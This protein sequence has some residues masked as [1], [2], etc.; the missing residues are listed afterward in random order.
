MKI[1]ICNAGSTSLKYRLLDMADESTLASGKMERVGSQQGSYSHSDRLGN[2]QSTTLPIPDYKT[3]IHLMLEQLVGTGKVL[4]TLEEIACVGF[5]VVHAKGV[6]GVQLLD[7]SVLGAMEQY[8]C[9][10]PAHNPPYIGAVLQ[11]RAL[12]PNTPMVGSFE[13]GFHQTMPPK[14]YLYPLPYEWC[15]QYGIRRYGF[16]GASHEYVATQTAKLLGS[17]DLR[18]VSCHLGGS[19]SLCAVKNGQ[20]VDT[21]MGFSLQT[22]IMHNNRCGDID[23]EIP[24]YLMEQQGFSPEQVHE[25]FAK[26]SGFLGLSGVSN[27]LRDIEEAAAKGDARAQTTIDCY[28]YSIKKR[29]GSYAA[30][31]GGLDA[32]AFAG[33][34]GENSAVIRR[35]VCE[36]MGFL[37]LELDE[38]ANETA[39]PDCV[40]STPTSRVKLLVVATNEEIVVARKAQA[41]LQSRQ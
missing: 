12:M 40:I 6:S 2:K 21:T 32:V 31:M 36:D 7:D 33:G 39:K 41:F 29:I 15:E 38:A 24:L 19:G 10:A 14:A 9:I 16:H 4:Q 26:K 30:A 17:Q 28:A 34:I 23:A 11:F 25:A 1:L 27:D 13:T 8:N 5:K 22:G 3:G 20:S 18:L 37:G 35:L